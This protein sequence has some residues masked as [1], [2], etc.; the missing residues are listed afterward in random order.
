NCLSALASIEPNNKKVWSSSG[1]W[2]VRFISFRSLSFVRFYA[3][4]CASFERFKIRLP[5]VIHR[6]L[7]FT[8][9]FCLLAVVLAAMRSFVVPDK[10][11]SPFLD[12]KPINASIQ[13]V[14][15]QHPMDRATLKKGGRS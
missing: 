10:D 5:G 6:S 14:D 12:R 8:E 3:R 1:F 4:F 2:S 9:N 15:G 13:T 7:V 11:C